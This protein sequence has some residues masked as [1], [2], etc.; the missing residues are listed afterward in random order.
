MMVLALHADH[1]NLPA[2]LAKPAPTPDM[3]NAWVCAGVSCLP[4]IADLGTLL[5][6]L[7]YKQ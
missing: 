7:D 5:R 6:T 2:A 4:P 1:T 3:V